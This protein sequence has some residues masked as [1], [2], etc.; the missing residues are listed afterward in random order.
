MLPHG[1]IQ[2]KIFKDPY[3][4][5]YRIIMLDITLYRDKIIMYDNCTVFQSDFS[6][7]MRI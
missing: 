5:E 4:L 6:K 1:L 3:Y 7:R 2:V